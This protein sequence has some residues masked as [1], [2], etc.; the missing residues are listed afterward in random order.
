MPSSSGF[1]GDAPVEE[2]GR[3]E[4]HT[5]LGRRDF[6]YTAARRLIHASH[7][8]QAA[9]VSID[10]KIMVVAA[11]QLELL[12]VVVDAGADRRG[13]GEIQRRSAHGPDLAGRNQHVIDG[14]E[15]VR[16]QREF[17]S[18]HVARAVSG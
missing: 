5:G 12:V 10:H 11:G 16:I 6:Q 13:A 4:L 2:V 7:E 14:G 18:K 8:L 9:A 17:M 15:A 3:I 1:S